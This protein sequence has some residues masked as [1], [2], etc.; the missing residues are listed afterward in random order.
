[1]LRKALYSTNISM[2]YTHVAFPS[3]R[4]IH[5]NAMS[6]WAVLTLLDPDFI[7]I[8]ICLQE[9]SILKYFAMS[10]EACAMA[11]LRPEDS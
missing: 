9:G 8:V 3:L 2:D 5:D 7:L 10:I 11:F 4:K 1:M 6:S